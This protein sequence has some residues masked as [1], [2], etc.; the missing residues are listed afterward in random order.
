[1]LHFE[2]VNEKLLE[3][4]NY[5]QQLSLL[6]SFYLV[7]GTSLALRFGHRISTDIDFF[8]HAE[9]DF[10]YIK[11]ELQQYFDILHLQNKKGLSGFSKGVK[12]DLVSH[13]YTLLES[14]EIIDGIRMAS[15]ADISAMKINAINN[16]G[17]R[18]DFIDLYFLLDSFSFDEILNHYA[19]KYKNEDIMIPMRSCIYF[20]DADIEQEELLC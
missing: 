20:D 8:T 18:K 16:R 11:E 13:K 4:L 14:I 1:M 9:V 17:K 2:T 10:E 15:L 6:D 3:R 12:T 19:L 5:L 7:G